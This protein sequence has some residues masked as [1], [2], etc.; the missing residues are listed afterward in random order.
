[1]AHFIAREVGGGRW[2]DESGN[3]VGAQRP[4]IFQGVDPQTYPVSDGADMAQVGADFG[5]S[6]YSWQSWFADEACRVTDAGL[7]AAGNVGLV[8]PR[9]N[10]KTLW[11]IV[12]ILTGLVLWDEKLI[13]Y[14]AHRFD[15]TMETF[16]A[17]E[18]ALDR[19]ISDF[20]GIPNPDYLASAAAWVAAV[21]GYK[22]I[23]KNGHEAIEF[24]NGCRIRFVARSENKG[25]GFSG[26]CVIFDEA[27]YRIEQTTIAALI[28]ALS[29]RPN[30]QVFYLSSS[31]TFDSNVL[32]KVRRAGLAKAPGYVYAEWSV[33]QGFDDPDTP[34]VDMRDV[35]L[36]YYAN[37]LL[38]IRITV[39]YVTETELTQLD[40]EHFMRE[41]LGVWD[42]APDSDRPV[43]A[44][45]W[46]GCARSATWLGG[47]I[48]PVA[49]AVDISRDSNTGSVVA[50][51]PVGG[52]ELGVAVLAHA[53]DSA[54]FRKTVMDLARQYGVA[55]VV[56]NYGP[57]A[58]LV[59]LIKAE[60]DRAG[61]TKIDVVEM[62]QSKTPAA[63]A[64]LAE[65]VRERE[66]VHAG[67]ASLDDAVRGAMKRYSGDGWVIDRRTEDHDVTPLLAVVAGVWYMDELDAAPVKTLTVDNIGIS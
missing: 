6:L 35:E 43:D 36:W 21:G 12:R 62:P 51:G 40:D 39:R 5:L 44:I 53:T 26:D 41:R 59:N 48:K 14:S 32:L 20:N 33:P 56:P 28:P 63:C 11:V 60:N 1:M 52:P 2:V 58:K 29:A 25:R 64:A 67:D 38:G 46:A 17:M 4:R 55:L 3:R 22:V 7:W 31:G 49:L 24:G 23:S 42:E 16:K 34:P 54:G 50:V 65:H 9:Q 18:T 15:T 37:P 27:G 13:V 66:I 61:I 30:P 19:S 45:A 10:G 47:R 57:A 8:I